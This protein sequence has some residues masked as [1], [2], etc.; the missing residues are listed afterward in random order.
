[1]IHHPRVCHE[2]ATWPAPTRFD[3]HN[4]LFSLAQLVSK[5]LL[6]YRKGRVRVLSKPKSFSGIHFAYIKGVLSC[7][8]VI[9]VLLVKE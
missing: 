1:M 3:T 8:R 9:P 5:T 7:L 4:I 2:L 6:R